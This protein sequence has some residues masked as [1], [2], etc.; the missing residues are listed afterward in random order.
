MR[1]RKARISLIC[2]AALL[3]LALTA[4]CSGRVNEVSD[5]VTTPVTVSD[6]AIPD[7][8]SVESYSIMETNA[9]KSRET[10]VDS[11]VSGL[12]DA[13][14]LEQKVAQMIMPSIC[15][16]G[17]DGRDVR[18]LSEVPAL[19]EAL[20]R[21]QYGGVILFSSN[22]SDTEQTVRL[23]SDLQANNARSADAET[24]GVIPY[25]VAADQEGGSVA[26]LTMGTRGTGGMAIGARQRGGAKR[27]VHGTDIRRGTR[28][29][30]H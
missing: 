14:S 3:M 10:G 4:G 26:R 28:G 1:I 20:R 19:A 22:I 9:D 17:K 5:S 8:S 21:H 2:V 18:V 11:C 12:L 25:L 15:V 6:G 29:A 30:G 7:A 23:I 27:P 24:V 13:M 16:W